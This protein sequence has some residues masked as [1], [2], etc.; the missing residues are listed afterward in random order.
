MASSAAFG[1]P[2][3][4]FTA[5]IFSSSSA[6]FAVRL[7]F[8]CSLFWFFCRFF[9]LFF[10]FRFNYLAAHS[11]AATWPPIVRCL[12]FAGLKFCRRLRIVSIYLCQSDTIGRSYFGHSQPPPAIEKLTVRP[13]G[14]NL[15][16]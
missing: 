7:R 15:S 4:Q 8:F 1:Q 6:G 11:S 2:E 9:S 3:R 14:S 16:S 5:L 13:P 12:F 10:F